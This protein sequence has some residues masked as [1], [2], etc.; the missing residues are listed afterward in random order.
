MKRDNKTVL[1]LALLL[2]SS[3][4]PGCNNLE[5][6]TVDNEKPLPV[7]QNSTFQNISYDIEG[8]NSPDNLMKLEEEFRKTDGDYETSKKLLL[9][10]RFLINLQRTVL[11]RK[12][13]LTYLNGILDFNQKGTIIIQKLIGLETNPALQGCYI[14]ELSKLKKERERI[15]QIYFEIIDEERGAVLY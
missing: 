8:E 15:R 12:D 4:N 9:K 7:V 5:R 13:R 2:S 6:K 10:A 11:S 3:L 14:E 1:S